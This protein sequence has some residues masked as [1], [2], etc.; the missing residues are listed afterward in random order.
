MPD[1]RVAGGD[2]G[3]GRV[4]PHLR[5]QERIWRLEA[6]GGSGQV[7]QHGLRRRR[8]HAA[9]RRHHGAHH[10]ALHLLARQVIDRD[11]ILVHDG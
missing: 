2:G 8:A 5:R 4:W 9:R 3:G 7:L 1:I 6:A 10:N 11:Y